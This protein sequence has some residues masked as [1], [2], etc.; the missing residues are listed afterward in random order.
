[1]ATNEK[2]D[3]I[4]GLLRD[5]KD[6]E[7]EHEKAL[8]DVMENAAENYG[9]LEKQLHDTINKMK[10]AEEKARS[11]SDQRVKVEAELTDLKARLTLLESQISEARA[12]GMRDGRAEGEQKA[13]DEVAEQLELVYNKSFRD[14][15]KAALKEAEVP[16]SSALFLRENTPL[17]YPNAELKASDDEAEEEVSDEG[18]KTEVEE[19]VG[20]EVIP[21]VIPTE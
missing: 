16:R 2:E 18:D 5:I 17:P 10:D 14:G 7:A 8:S 13:L 1:M 15:W 11:E 3:R 9:K 4:A 6:K 19:L 12:G 21:I 20:S